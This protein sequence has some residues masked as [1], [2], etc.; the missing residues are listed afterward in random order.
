M[1]TTNHRHHSKRI[2]SQERV[3]AIAWRDNSSIIDCHRIKHVFAFGGIRFD[4]TLWQRL[5]N[6]PAQQIVR[7]VVSPHTQTIIRPIASNES[8]QKNM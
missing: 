5:S 4:M 8:K 3:I 1:T 6:G 7:L 2:G